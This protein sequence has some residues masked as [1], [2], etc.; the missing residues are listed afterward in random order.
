MKTS[1]LDAERRRNEVST[2]LQFLE[3]GAKQNLM[4]VHISHQW[5]D[6][7]LGEALL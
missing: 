1:P 6:K 4:P 2:P 5:I 7:Q 3:R